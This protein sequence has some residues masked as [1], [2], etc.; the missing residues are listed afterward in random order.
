MIIDKADRIKGSKPYYFATKLKQVAEMNSRGLQVINL[1]I[2]SPDLPP[3]PSAFQGLVEGVWEDGASRYQPYAGIPELRSAF[4]TFYDR[5]FDVA[6]DPDTQVLPLLGS[7]EGIQHISMSFLQE[8]DI[9]LVP[10]PGYPTYRISASFAGAT[11]LPYRLTAKQGWLPDLADI[12]ATT[13]MAKVKIM[14]VNYPHMPTG[15]RATVRFYTEL[16]AWARKHQVLL[17]SDNPYNFILNEYYLSPLQVLGAEEVCIELTSLSKCF[18]MAGWRVGALVGGAEYV[19]TVATTKSNMDSG[20]FKPVQAAAVE[21]LKE[22]TFWFTELNEVYAARRE[23]AYE[24][25][26]ALSCTYEGDTAGMFVWGRMPKYA[27]VTSAE[28]IETILQKANVFIT[29]GHIFGAE[30]EGYIRISLCNPEAVL[31]E[32]LHRMTTSLRL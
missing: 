25:L 31:E 1:G 14:W 29:P 3:P 16:I 15:A 10:D 9:A 28:L 11:A 13:D 21:V 19:A 17:C 18:N 20:M 27:K 24:I 8:G 23:A 26:D 22:S 32:A 30:G 2:G 6:L 12:A 5:W 4:A 7:K